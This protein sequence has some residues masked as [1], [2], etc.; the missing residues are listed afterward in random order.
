MFRESARQSIVREVF[1]LEC[2]R[3]AQE[4]QAVRH[5][6]VHSFDCFSAYCV[7][8]ELLRDDLDVERQLGAELKSIVRRRL[9]EQAFVD[10]A[11]DVVC[12]RRYQLPPEQEV[13][14]I[15]TVIEQMRQQS[16]VDASQFQP[17]PGARLPEKRSWIMPR[18]D[19]TGPPQQGQRGRGRMGGPSAAGTGG[20]CV[21][22]KCG[23]K[24]PHS[25]GQP[26]NQK[27]CPRCG[28]RMTRGR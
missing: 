10:G 3:K 20:Q 9:N 2:Q 8:S 18:S 13:D 12:D 22:P 5:T 1:D 19:G 4:D 15:V 21:C 25:A 14:L 11:G 27:T 26:C 7:L 6:A 16:P 24:T 17:L 23:H 28:T